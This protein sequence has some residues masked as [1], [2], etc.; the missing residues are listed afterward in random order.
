MQSAGSPAE[1]TAMVAHG[2]DAAGRAADIARADAN[3]G[4][5]DRILRWIFVY[6]S[7]ALVTL[8]HLSVVTFQAGLSWW[9]WP[10]H[11][12]LNLVLADLWPIYWLFLR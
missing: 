5:E 6:A 3:A 1:I 11:L 10:G 8:I 9:A 7:G 12:L 2:P 4:P